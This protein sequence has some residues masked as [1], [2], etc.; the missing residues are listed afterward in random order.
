MSLERVYALKKSAKIKIKHRQA[1]RHRRFVRRS[2]SSSEDTYY[3]Y[4]AR[5]PYAWYFIP[6]ECDAPHTAVPTGYQLHTG[7]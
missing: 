5:Q 4:T 1:F 2:F 7:V 3:T 6:K